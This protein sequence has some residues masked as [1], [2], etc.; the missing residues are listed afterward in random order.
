MTINRKEYYS[1]SILKLMS[2]IESNT[3]KL[4]QETNSSDEQAFWS[5]YDSGD[6]RKLQVIYNNLAKA[7]DALEM[8]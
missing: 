2:R 5:A 1:Q 6:V 8:E 4:F 3:G 7:V